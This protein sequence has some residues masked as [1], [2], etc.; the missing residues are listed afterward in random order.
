MAHHKLLITKLIFSI[1]W[2]GYLRSHVSSHAQTLTH[3]QWRS[4]WEYKE[5]LVAKFPM[6][7]TAQ[8]THVLGLLRLR[9]GTGFTYEWLSVPLFNKCSLI[10]STFPFSPTI[11]LGNC[12]SHHKGTRVPSCWVILKLSPASAYPW[13]HSYQPGK[14][15]TAKEKKSI[16]KT[17]LPA[18]GL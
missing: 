10:D 1:Y 6:L 15:V 5:I 7:A 17:Y 4:F 13:S 3:L 2:S 12:S 8:S 16:F 9:N 11:W 18:F 14:M